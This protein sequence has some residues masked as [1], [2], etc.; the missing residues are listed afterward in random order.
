[1]RH[2]A[3]Q[4]LFSNFEQ[5]FERLANMQRDTTLPIYG[6]VLDKK[7]KDVIVTLHGVI[8]TSSDPY[9]KRLAYLHLARV[10][11]SLKGMVKEDCRRGVIS[12]ENRQSDA[13]IVIKLYMEA[14]RITRKEDVHGIIRDCNRWAALAK[15]V[16]LLPLVL[17]DGETTKI[18]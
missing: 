16:P 13:T 17:S 5:T 4:F 3:K 14:T 11:T 18:L 7:V 10:L 12:R 15:N 8:K 2:D 6:S 1:M 9:M